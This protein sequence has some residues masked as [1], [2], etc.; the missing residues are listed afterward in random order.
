MTKK[1]YGLK[2]STVRKLEDE[3]CDYPN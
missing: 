1:K 2:L 3:L